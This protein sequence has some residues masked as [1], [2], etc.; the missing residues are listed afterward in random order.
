MVKNLCLWSITIALLAAGCA[1]R[2]KP[3]EEMIR[4]S[5]KP[6]L[7]QP[8]EP[9][10]K[11]A[12]EPA[13]RPRAHWPKQIRPGENLELRGEGFGK[14]GTLQVGRVNADIV[15]WSDTLIVAIMPSALSTERA[16]LELALEN[17]DVLEHYVAVVQELP[18][19]YES[20]LSLDEQ[21][22]QQVLQTKVS[23]DSSIETRC[24]MALA[25]FELRDNAN[26]Q[27]DLK[28]AKSKLGGTTTGRAAAF[29]YGVLAYTSRDAN[30]DRAA[31]FFQ[32]A[33]E[34]EPD[35][36]K[37]NPLPYLLQIKWLIELA[38]KPGNEESA[39][40]AKNLIEFLRENRSLSPAESGALDHLEAQV[41]NRASE[42]PRMEQ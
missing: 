16:K 22:Y 23:P 25:T 17:G 5:N 39:K 14:K 1:D 21:G 29:Y 12:S 20:I 30:P 24:L 34:A 41:P 3:T 37:S 19:S 13:S 38:G 31:E 4:D 8:R 35:D 15:D 27:A 42:P 33:S 18:R 32:T 40:G 11:I 2:E 7:G 10:T 36:P 6:Q 28:R 26:A 9:L